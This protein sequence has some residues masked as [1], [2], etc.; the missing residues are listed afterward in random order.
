MGEPETESSFKDENALWMSARVVDRS[1]PAIGLHQTNPRTSTARLV[2]P[3]SSA[4]GLPQ[5][6]ITDS[7]TVI[8]THEQTQRTIDNWMMAECIVF[9]MMKSEYWDKMMHLLMTALKGFSNLLELERQLNKSWRKVTKASKF[10]ARRHLH[11]LDQATRTMTVEHANKYKVARAIACA[12]P[13]IP[14]KRGRGRPR[15][16]AATRGGTGDEEADDVEGSNLAGGPAPAHVT[17]KWGRPQK[18]PVQEEEATQGG[19]REKEVEDVEGGNLARGPAPA[20]GTTKWGQSQK[21]LVQE[22]EAAPEGTS[23]DECGGGGDQKYGSSDKSDGS[24]DGHDRSGG[25][26][27]TDDSGK[28]DEGERRRERWLFFEGGGRL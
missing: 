2:D 26:D 9:N 20:R 8:T 14:A 27:G 6:T 5:T 16:E 23:N 18:E 10:L 12:P 15:N 1:G 24:G 17:R 13:S 28:E 11:E 19:T 3:L 21:E 7:A 25:S 22:E 4:V